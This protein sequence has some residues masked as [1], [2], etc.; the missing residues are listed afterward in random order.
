MTDFSMNDILRSFRKMRM[1]KSTGQGGHH[2]YHHTQ[3]QPPHHSQ[4][5]QA[6]QHNYPV[7]QSKDLK[8]IIKI[9]K[10][11][12]IK[13]KITHSA[14][15][16]MVYY[17]ANQLLI[18]TEQPA[19]TQFCLQVPP[20][21][22]VTGGEGA[23]PLG[24]QQEHYELLQTPQ[25]RLMQVQQQQTQEQQQFVSYSYQL[26]LQQHQQQQQHESVTTTTTASV[27]AAT[28][29]PAA[30]AQRIKTEPTPTVSYSAATAQPR[31]QNGT[32]PQ[33]KC[34]QCGMTFGSKSAHTSHTKSH[35]K[36][37]E[38]ALLGAGGAPHGATSSPIELNEAGLP[39]GIPKSPTIK[40]L[41]NVA[42]GADPYQCNVCQK[43]F[44]VPARLIRH[45]RTH[46]G[47]RPFECEFCHKLFSVK[48][49]LQVHRRIHTKER[50]Y[51]CDV[52]GRA[53]E[54]SGKLHRH[55]RIH[56]GERPHKCSV[57]EKTFIQSGQLVIHMRTHTGEKP[58]KCPEPGCGKG[59]T[60]SKQLKVH[61]RTHT[62]EK[63][64]HC[65]ICFRDFGYNHVLKLHRVQHYGSKCYKCTICDETFKNKKEMEAHIK[66][67]A[68]EIPDD[69]A[70]A[71]AG[72]T[73]VGSTS[74]A[75]SSSSSLQGITSNS[76][77]SNNSPPSSPPAVKKPRQPRQPR[78][79]KAA[80]AAAA[81]G[82]AVLAAPLSPSSPSSTYSPSASSLAS[83]PPSTVQYLPAVPLDTDALSRD[84]GVS[85]AQ[86]ALS[87]YADEELPTDLSMQQSQSQP[88]V[89]EPYQATPSLVEQQPQAQPPLTINPALL[90]A[91]SIAR[92]DEDHHVNDE[93]V[94][95]AAWQMMQLRRG[96]AATPP[97]TEAVPQASP[98][99][100]L[101]VS[102]LAANYDDTHEAT[103][104]IEHF[105]RGDLA[106]HGLHKGYAPVPKYESALPNPDIVRRVE[107]AI[108]LRSSTESP[109]RSS[110]PESDSLMMA[111]RN[112]MTL[113]LRKRKHY[114]NK[115]DAGAC[116]VESGGNNS[117]PSAA[118]AGAGDGATTAA[119][120]ADASSNN[121]NSKMM[122][123]SSVIQF[124]KAS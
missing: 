44:A 111:D 104:L 22:T 18:K 31:K 25:Q 84:S 88:M 73:A 14:T 116:Q 45:Y 66:G 37:A 57:C 112:V 76:E 118:M 62:G 17:P 13:E 91:A 5:I 110:S 34:E 119:N 113:P 103:V 28:A 59:F 58:Y 101:H 95:A 122:R 24:G 64:Y 75:S 16:N 3:Q 55:M 85:S 102:D 120:S 39:V 74:S 124:A 71:A 108:G 9:I 100:T 109:E 115:G 93:D 86:P 27:A 2:Q 106:R 26:A 20:P 30:T 43:T 69:E 89:Y 72:A 98:Q 52:C 54:H 107:A 4:N 60:C 114:M 56:T 48:E 61:S 21:L 1:N 105:K 92:Q 40:P 8:K 50:P 38:M 53:F 33:F 32:K 12:L 117:S 7:Q 79:V 63:P 46:T 80:A 15:T 90:E 82:A 19:Q 41:A 65:D 47:E 83:P 78:G 87:S 99:P 77:C 97:T 29:A 49:N 70:E 10:K 42:A 51:K 96:H 68:N 121:N 11:N 81:A 123:M 67:H 36:N 94:H 35:A 6:Y 23:A